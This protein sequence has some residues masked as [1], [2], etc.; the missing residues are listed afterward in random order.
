MEDFKQHSL[1]KGWWSRRQ[2]VW[3]YPKASCLN[4]IVFADMDKIIKTENV[5]G[6]FLWR[7]L[8]L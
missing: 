5:S 6:V 7:D 4:K 1:L 8:R 2:G 3:C